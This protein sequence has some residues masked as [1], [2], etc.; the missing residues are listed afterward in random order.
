[1]ITNFW[2]HH[3]TKIDDLTSD[4]RKDYFGMKVIVRKKLINGEQT[5]SY[6]SLMFGFALNFLLRVR[7]Q[8]MGRGASRAR[9]VI[10]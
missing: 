4:L 7:E 8:G 9:Q 2:R 3:Y 5:C 1:M 10:F 6:I